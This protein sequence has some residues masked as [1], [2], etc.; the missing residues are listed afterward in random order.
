MG[1]Y[2][3]M[4]LGDMGAVIIKIEKTSGYI[5]RYV[6]PHRNKG[7]GSNFLNLNRNK[8]SLVLDLKDEEEKQI[9]LDMVKDSDV[10]IH[11]FR[12][13]TMESLGLSYES[14][15]KEKKSRIYSGMYGYSQEGDY[16][17]YNAYYYII[18]V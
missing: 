18:Q 9:L 10:I 16:G 3:T 7:M 1:P 12:K 15:S 11:S 14:I 4:L 2:C 13:K 5:T 17:S 8:R 6:G